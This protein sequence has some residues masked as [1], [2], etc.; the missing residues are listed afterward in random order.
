VTGKILLALVAVLV[1]ASLTLGAVFTVIWG[2]LAA[3]SVENLLLRILAV[4]ADALLGSLLLIGCIYLATQLAVRILGV[5]RAEFPLPP[6][7]GP[8]EGQSKK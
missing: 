3:I 2:T 5:G 1:A 8:E 4:T 7:S 6:M